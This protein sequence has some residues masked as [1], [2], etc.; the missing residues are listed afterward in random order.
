M[1]RP[2]SRPAF[3]VNPSVIVRRVSA[4]WWVSSWAAASGSP[5]SM[6]RQIRRCSSRDRSIP[7]GSAW[8]I[9]RSRAVW[10]RRSAIVVANGSL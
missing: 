3:L 1:S 4:R 8:A 9:P 5:S 6:A 2:P 7:R 10:P